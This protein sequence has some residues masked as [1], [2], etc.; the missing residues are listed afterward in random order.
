[1][2][3]NVH[4]HAHIHTQMYA[5]TH[6]HTR[7]HTHTHTRPHTPTHKPGAIA[8]VYALDAAADACRASFKVLV[9]GT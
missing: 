3:I 5:H 2:C 9:A 6:T 8:L 4:T 7:A 1:M